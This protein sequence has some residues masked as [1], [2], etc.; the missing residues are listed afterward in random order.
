[1]HFKLIT[2][3]TLV[4]DSEYRELARK[5]SDFSAGSRFNDPELLGKMK[6]VLLGDTAV[7]KSCVVVR[8]VRNEYTEHQVN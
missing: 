3:V 2:L 5:N 6:L 8:F 4:N 7:G 1:M